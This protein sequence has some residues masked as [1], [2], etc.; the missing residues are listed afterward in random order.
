VIGDVVDPTELFAG[1]TLDLTQRGGIRRTGH[2][3]ADSH[4]DS[5]PP[6]A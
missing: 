5:L 2:A 1:A 6:D 3:Q 4:R